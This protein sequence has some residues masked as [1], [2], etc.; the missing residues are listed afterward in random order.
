[1]TLVTKG[2]INTEQFYYGDI[3]LIFSRRLLEQS[4]Y[5]I[6]YI[7]HNGIITQKSLFSWNIDKFREYETIYDNNIGNEVIFHDS[8]SLDFLCQVISNDDNRPWKSLIP[9]EPIQNNIEPNMTLLPY[10]SYVDDRI[11]TGITLKFYERAFTYAW[12]RTMAIVAGVY[13]MEASQDELLDRIFKRSSYLYKNRDKQ[14]IDELL[15][16]HKG[17]NKS[18]SPVNQPKDGYRSKK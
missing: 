8:I 2:N 15:T 11:Y 14:N 1:M 10:L 5:H 12:I 3:M 16:Y 6:N 7:D 4:N 17:S 9:K 18:L 13:T